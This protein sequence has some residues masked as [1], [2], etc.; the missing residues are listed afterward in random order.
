MTHT[1]RH[2]AQPA[3]QGRS[4][5]FNLTW[6]AA[7][8]ISI[9]ILAAVLRL[10]NAA[11]FADGNTYYTAAA[12]NMLRSPSH[13]F[14]A[15]ADAGG[16]T[17]D[18]PPVALWIQALFAGVL[19]VSG[20]SVTLPSILAG[21]L[22]VLLLYHL[23][24]KWHGP[25]AGLIAA[26]VLAVTPISVAVD[27]T[28][29]LDSILIFALLL[30]T[31]A[32]VR[33]VE[34][35]K[36]RHLLIGAALIGVGFNIKMLQAYLIVPALFGLYFLSADLPWRKKFTQVM[37]AGMLAL[38]VSLSWAAVVD[39]T[40]AD[41][42]P[43]V[44]GSETNSVLEL[45]LGY[46]GMS[47]LLG[48]DGRPGENAPAGSAPVAD[49]SASVTDR[50]SVNADDNGAGIG[51]ARPSG[52]G[53]S[54]EIGDA[55]VTRLFESALAN[56]L[57]WLLPFALL[58]AGLMAFH[59]RLTLPLSGAHRSLMLW[60]GWLVTGV[61]FFSVSS[62]FHAYYLATLAPALAA[63]VGI[64]AVTLWH[65]RADRPR[66]ALGL[67]AGMLGATLGVQALTLSYYGALP[68]LL[69]AAAAAI[70]AAIADR[71]L[72]QN[73]AVAVLTLAALLIVPAA[74]SGLTA[75]N[76]NNA[77]LPQAYIDQDGGGMAGIAQVPDA[78]RE[79]ADSALLALVSLTEAADTTYDLVVDSSHT[80]ST[81][82][83]ESDLDVLFFGGFNGQDDI[84]SAEDIAAMVANSEVGYVLTA[85]GPAGSGAAWV[86]ETCTIVEDIALPT[87]GGA[88]GGAQGDDAALRPPPL[89]MTPP[90]G[91]GP[92]GANGGAQNLYNCTQ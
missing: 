86:T 33:A 19:G 36:W 35:G 27:R 52:P 51:G 3:P 60:G 39:L 14:Y 34:T 66:L 72:N 11:A 92:G 5:P 85:G 42:R 18:K 41:Q 70:A 68:L 65:M 56:E 29:N 78:A 40:P 9:V 79:R 6:T 84:Y 77:N 45:A 16:V 74:W 13:F 38:A 90:A 64:G 83:L 12:E 53:G 89:G 37:A 48:V 26:L 8:L 15:V 43:Y 88:S 76:A 22:S 32:F 50:V 31:W 61:V 62:F 57:A 44:G 46:N 4:L 30:A 73:R 75:I 71:V 47:R 24:R 82:T 67:A 91:M 81:I 2:I 10:V 69:P 63:L 80:G 21:V 25:T 59:T 58:S 87:L 54:D 49:D 1:H 23:V 28:N 17:V 55:G 20:F 7:A